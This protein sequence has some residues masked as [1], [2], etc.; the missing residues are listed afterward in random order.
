M[1]EPQEEAEPLYNPDNVRHYKPKA[2]GFTMAEPQ[3]Q[4]PPVQS[5]YPQ[6]IE[7]I[8]ITGDQSLNMYG[9]NY[10]GGAR[11]LTLAT[12]PREFEQPEPT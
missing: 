6:E 12:K 10:Q 7:S 4:P 8:D 1:D 2:M 5:F 9:N 11:P 3:Q